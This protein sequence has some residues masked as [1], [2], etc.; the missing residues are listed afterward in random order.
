MLLIMTTINNDLISTLRGIGFSKNEA[1]IYLTTLELG[2]SPILEISKKSGLKRPTCYVLLDELIWKGHAN[3]TDDG[4]RSIYSV[5]SPRQLLRSI[6]HRHQKFTSAIAE[7]EGIASHSPGKPLLR[8][9]EGST[10]VMQVYNL[11]LECPAGEEIFIYGSAEVEANYPEF[12]GDYIAERV[13]RGIL[14]RA[15]L[16]D[17]PANRSIVPRDKAELRQTRFLPLEQFNQRTEVNIFGD[18][19]AYIAHS[20]KEPFATIIEN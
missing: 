16:S 17:T 13:Q 3:K 18:M 14:V 20:Q 11:S 1:T 9:Y 19:I 15:I 4:K 12:I 10:G 6:N 8:A 2:P 7:L 5:N